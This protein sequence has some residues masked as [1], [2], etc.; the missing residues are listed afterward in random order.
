MSGGVSGD[1]LPARKRPRWAAT[2]R[3]DRR[4]VFDRQGGHDR[5][6]VA[7]VKTE[8]HDIL[9]GRAIRGEESAVCLPDD[10]RGDDDLEFAR[11]IGVGRDEPV[12]SVAWER[13]AGAIAKVDG[14]AL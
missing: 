4:E 9:E 11:L 7:D 14:P 13:P 12:G 3:D 1:R 10:P 5:G 6:S 8:R 2:R